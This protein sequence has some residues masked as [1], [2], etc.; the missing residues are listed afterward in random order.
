LNSFQHNTI[1]ATLSICLCHQ[2]SQVAQR[3]MALHL[4]PRGVTT[5]PG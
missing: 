4:S 1:M 3:S 5:D 2:S